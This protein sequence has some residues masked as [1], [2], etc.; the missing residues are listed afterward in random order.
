MI[1]CAFKAAVRGVSC[2]TRMRWWLA[3]ITNAALGERQEG[4][5]P[6]ILALSSRIVGI[7]GAS[8]IV[9]KQL[10]AW[11]GKFL[12]V[13]IASVTARC[14]FFV[15]NSEWQGGKSRGGGGGSGVRTIIC[16]LERK[17]KGCRLTIVRCPQPFGAKES[18]AIRRDAQDNLVRL[19]AL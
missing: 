4:C 10:R 11:K 8:G 5:T 17:A 15:G 18:L 3:E 16:L 2:E 14:L 1:Y 7:I 13:Y 19:N 9:G 12:V 6:S